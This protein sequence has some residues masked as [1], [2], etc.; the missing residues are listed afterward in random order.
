MSAEDEEVISDLTELQV[1]VVD[2]CRVVIFMLAL[3]GAV[4]PCL[5]RAC[6]EDHATRFHERTASIWRNGR[7][8]SRA[9]CSES[10]RR[11]FVEAG[12]P[13][14]CDPHK[15]CILPSEEF[16]LFLSFWLKIY[17]EMI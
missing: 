12:A 14:S 1:P 17:Q 2:R 10:V 15:I 5:R 4:R 8:T 11:G 6:Q 16:S 7:I 13:L 3:S 9:C